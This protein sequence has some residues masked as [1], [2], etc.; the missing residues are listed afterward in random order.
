[1][2]RGMEYVLMVWKEQSFSAAAQKLYISQPALSNTI[3]RIEGRIGSPIFDRSV[4]PIQ[5]TEVGKEYIRTVE[6]ITAL[7]ENFE[8]FLNDTQNLQTG[9]IVIGCGAMVSS[10]ILPDMIAAYKEI[11]P[12]VEI[13]VVEGGEGEL[14][15]MLIDG[16]ADLVIENSS[17]STALF[18]RK[19]LKKEH[20]LL[21]A[22]KKWELN[23]EL[24]AWQQSRENIISGLYLSKRYPAVPLEKFCDKPFLLL[25]PEDENYDRALRICSSSGFSPKI[26]LLLNQ[27]LTSYNMACA[28]LGAAFVSDTLIKK[29]LPHSGIVYYKLQGEATER[30]ICFYYKRNRYISHCMQRFL[31]MANDGSQ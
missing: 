3:K 9:R 20:I 30:D 21:A 17:L 2:F 7:Q 29:A 4:S 5:L 24:L 13:K 27:Q 26:T 22:P 18:E 23:Q 31:D 25:A 10:Y 19:F 1:M 11:Y 15:K 6:Q 8:H 28:G 16:T 12:Q 14:E